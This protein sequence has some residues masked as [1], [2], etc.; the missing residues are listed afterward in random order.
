MAIRAFLDDEIH[1]F[2]HSLESFFWVLFWICIHYGEPNKGRTVL[3]SEKWNYS[4]TEE[5]VSVYPLGSY[6]DR[7]GR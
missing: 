1:S 4:D 7:S 2:M 5:L 6:L 3:Q